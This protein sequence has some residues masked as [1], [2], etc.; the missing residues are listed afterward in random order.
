MKALELKHDLSH[1]DQLVIQRLLKKL[2]ELDAEFKKN[3]YAVVENLEREEDTE[4]EQAT[5]NDHEDK[6]ANFQGRLQVL[7]EEKAKHSPP[8]YQVST[9]P[10][11]KQLDCIKRKINGVQESVDN[12]IRDAVVDRCLLQQF[13]EQ[14]PSLKSG[15]ANI[16]DKISSLEK[17]RP[18]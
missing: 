5:L 1:T 8:E 6:I 10:I 18:A 16:K 17:D 9:P 11:R 12:A 7:V 14:T 3:H 13:D 15:L 2:Q 4:D